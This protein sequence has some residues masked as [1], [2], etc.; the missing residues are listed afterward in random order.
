MSLLL[1]PLLSLNPASTTRT[2]LLLASS[3]SCRLLAEALADAGALAIGLDDKAVL[4]LLLVM[5]LLLLLSGSLSLAAGADLSSAAG[6]VP[7]LLSSRSARYSAE[8]SGVFLTGAAGAAA[9]GG[10][11]QQQQVAA[12]EPHVCHASCCCSHEDC[13][14]PQ[15]H[16]TAASSYM[17]PLL[18]KYFE[19]LCQPF[20]TAKHYT[21]LLSAVQ[22]AV[23]HIC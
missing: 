21:T 3:T 16:N 15:Q 7:V 18:P 4:L 17:Q 13:L 5:P 22:P 9:A 8:N 11:R 6:A 19:Y 23:W 2:L 12:H 20:T 10:Q 1:L 14:Q